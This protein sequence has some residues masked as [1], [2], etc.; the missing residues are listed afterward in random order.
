MCPTIAGKLNCGT[1]KCCFNKAKTHGLCCDKFA[2]CKH[3]PGGEASCAHFDGE[4]WPNGMCPT[5]AGKLNCGT[6]K[7]CYDKAKKH[8]LCCDKFAPCK[9]G[10]GGAASCAHADDEEGATNASVELL[11]EA[12]PVFSQVR[13]HNTSYWEH[14]ASY[15]EQESSYGPGKPGCQ[16]GW[17]VT[18]CNQCKNLYKGIFNGPH[19]TMPFYCCSKHR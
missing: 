17:P 15:W 8:G 14:N 3:G 10:P 4:K 9:H 11:E 5:I 16:V 6:G 13:A 12:E 19:H 7:C 1:G 2:P 18:D